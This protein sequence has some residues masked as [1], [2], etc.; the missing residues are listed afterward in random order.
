MSSS[1][2]SFKA[3]H[4]S[5]ECPLFWWYRHCFLQS[6]LFGLTTFLWGG[7]NLALSDSSR[8]LPLSAFTGVYLE[9]WFPRSRL[10]LHL[11]PHWPERTWRSFSSLLFSP[12]ASARAWLQNSLSSSS[13]MNLA[14][15]FLRSSRLVV[16]CIHR[17]SA[18]GPG[19]KAD[20][21]VHGNVRTEIPNTHCHF[22]EPINEGS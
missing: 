4:S 11:S 6:A 17:L 2:S 22:V 15:L 14:A 20:N 13:C 12:L 1:I 19:R 8:I 18:N 16:G 5:V 21:M 3:W 7:I 9:N 10:S